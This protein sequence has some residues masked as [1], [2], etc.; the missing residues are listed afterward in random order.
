MK[1]SLLVIPLLAAMIFSAMLTIYNKHASRQLFVDLR[2]L[3]DARDDL[4]IEWSQLQ[5]EYST[6]ATESVVDEVAKRSLNM[7]S[8]DPA[9]VVYL[10]Q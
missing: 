4:Q 2:A 5:L 6:L 10:I 9:A 8:P 7:H 3:Q 1:S